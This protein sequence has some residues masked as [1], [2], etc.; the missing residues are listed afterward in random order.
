MAIE[1]EVVSRLKTHPTTMALSG[2]RVYPLVLPTEVSP[3]ITYR[4]LVGVPEIALDGSVIMTSVQLEISAWAE[5][6]EQ[7]RTLAD[8]VFA[9]LNGWSS[10]GVAVSHAEFGPDLFEPDVPNNVQYRCLIQAECLDRS[11]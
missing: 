7:A 4:R 9:A 6:Y 5:T 2:N 10:N 1:A 11:Y 8:G 3:A